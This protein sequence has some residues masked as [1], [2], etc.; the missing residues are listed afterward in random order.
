MIDSPRDDLPVVLI[1]DDDPQL[2]GVVSIILGSSDRELVVAEDVKEGLAVVRAR[3]IAVVVA[4]YQMPGKSGLDFLA[5]LRDAG[6]TMPFILMSGD[7]HAKVDAAASGHTL[8]AV[9][10]KPVSPIE[11]RRLVADAIAARGAS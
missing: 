9:L 2:R 5:E 1:V 10:T 3:S 6:Y 4:D 11:L 8:Q 7:S